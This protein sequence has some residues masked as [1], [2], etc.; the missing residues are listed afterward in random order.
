M[1][2]VSSYKKKLNN[3]RKKLISGKQMRGCAR[4]NKFKKIESLLDT[5]LPTHTHTYIKQEYK[6]FI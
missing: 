4:K 3:I 2:Q 5:E 1:L 6:M